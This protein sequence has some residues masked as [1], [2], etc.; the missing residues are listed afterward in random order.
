MRYSNI[1]ESFFDFLKDKKKKETES[2]IN[3]M[4]NFLNN[5]LQFGYDSNLLLP[6]LCPLKKMAES[7]VLSEKVLNNFIKTINYDTIKLFRV[8][9]KIWTGNLVVLM[10]TEK[11]STQKVTKSYNPSI[12]SFHDYLRDMES[13]PKKR[14]YTRRSDYNYP[15][16]YRRQYES[17]VSESFFS[18]F[19]SWMKGGNVN[20]EEINFDNAIF[21]TTHFLVKYPGY[22]YDKQNDTPGFIFLASLA[23]AIQ[24]PYNS[25]LELFKQNKFENAE[26]INFKMEGIEGPVV[27]FGNPPIDRK[28]QWDSWNAELQSKSEDEIETI[29]NVASEVEKELK[30]ETTATKQPETEDLQ[31]TTT[32]EV[33]VES[34]MID[35]SKKEKIIQSTIESL[36]TVFSRVKKDSLNI[37]QKTL[38][39]IFDRVSEENNLKILKE[40]ITSLFENNLEYLKKTSFSKELFIETSGKKKLKSDLNEN[41]IGIMLSNFIWSDI[42]TTKKLIEYYQ[43]SPDISNDT[44]EMENE[45][46]VTTTKAGER[47]ITNT[48]NILRMGEFL[49]MVL[50]SLQEKISTISTGPLVDMKVQSILTDSEY[51]DSIILAIKSIIQDFPKFSK[52]DQESLLNTVFIEYKEKPNTYFISQ[53]LDSAVS[54]FSDYLINEIPDVFLKKIEESI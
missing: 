43:T 19:M 20:K 46:V 6:G 37:S 13:Y 2:I 10:P 25:L 54:I 14:K 31:K 16:D 50:K 48:E 17:H 26:I 40:F 29:A 4:Q 41:I 18:D 42:P 27:I 53:N 32:P 45:E 9:S 44:V 33:K 5:N 8:N 49:K 38:L 11:S 24:I 12:D 7:I 52:A 3:R 1:H 15:Y 23:N 39:N 22:D 28:A 34:D 21:Q 36:I 30:Q 47:E 35:E 51:Y